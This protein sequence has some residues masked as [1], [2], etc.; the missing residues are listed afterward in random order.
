MSMTS[1]LVSR[2]RV[3]GFELRQIAA[4]EKRCGLKRPK[5]DVGV[6]LVG[7]QMRGMK[8]RSPTDLADDEHIRIVPM[9][10]ASILRDFVFACAIIHHAFPVVANVIRRAP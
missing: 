2:P 3:K 6:L 9:A 8:I 10:G 5:A 1:S 7:R 4:D